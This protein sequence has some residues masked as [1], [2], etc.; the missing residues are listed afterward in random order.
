MLLGPSK[1]WWA[2]KIKYR[3]PIPKSGYRF[4]IVSRHGP[5]TRIRRPVQGVSLGTLAGTRFRRHRRNSSTNVFPGAQ[6]DPGAEPQ[7]ESHPSYSCV[8]RVAL[9]IIQRFTLGLC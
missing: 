4:L 2:R 1:T 7:R 9:D 5:G 3:R 6:N 8:A